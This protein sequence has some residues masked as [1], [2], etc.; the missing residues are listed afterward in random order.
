M[1]TL[2]SDRMRSLLERRDALLSLP[3]AALHLGGNGG[4]SAALLDAACA[5]IGVRFEGAQRERGDVALP[6]S[7]WGVGR[8]VAV[9]RRYAPCGS[10]LV[11]VPAPRRAAE[12]DGGGGEDSSSAALDDWGDLAAGVRA[13]APAI[14]PPIAGVL[15]VCKEA[16]AAPPLLLSEGTPVRR[17]VVVHPACR[18]T[19]VA[20]R[21]LSR[22]IELSQTNALFV[23]TFGRRGAIDARLASVA[24]IVPVTAAAAAAARRPVAAAAAAGWPPPAA[25]GPLDGGA[26]WGLPAFRA[27]AAAALRR[28]DPEALARLARA[29]AAVARIRALGGEPPYFF[30]S[31][32]AGGKPPPVKK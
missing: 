31:L 4:D 10:L 28:S 5:L 13:A 11:S 6:R 29:E 23:L 32:R 15:Q 22:I 24:L 9:D 14:P 26:A 8:E 30:I 27:A 16:A 21:A 12:K 18:L 1:T 20:Q 3:C 17:I 19:R 2:R 7:E 25:A